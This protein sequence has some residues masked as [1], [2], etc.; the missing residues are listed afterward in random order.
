M[1]PAFSVEHLT[2]GREIILIL[3]MSINVVMNIT[4]I[5][6]FLPGCVFNDEDYAES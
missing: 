2:E 4:D 3:I 5:G 1:I 6:D